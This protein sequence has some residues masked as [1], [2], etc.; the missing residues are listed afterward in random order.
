MKE[1]QCKNIEEL[2]VKVREILQIKEGKNF[3]F[4][5]SPRT[6][7]LG[8]VVSIYYSLEKKYETFFKVDWITALKNDKILEIKEKFNKD[9]NDFFSSL[10]QE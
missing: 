10:F 6:G 2:T 7:E 8:V 1:V 3:W 4:M 9:M 5:D